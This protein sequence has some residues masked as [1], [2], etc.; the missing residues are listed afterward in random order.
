MKQPFADFRIL[1]FQTSKTWFYDI[2]LLYDPF[3]HLALT[4][5]YLMLSTSIDESDQ[6]FY[7]KRFRGDIKGQGIINPNLNAK[8]KI[9]IIYFHKILDILIKLTNKL[10]IDKIL[11]FKNM[12]TNFDSNTNVDNIVCSRVTYQK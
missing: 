8:T 7:I 5:G 9:E 11:E 10:V 3:K 6:K 12:Q 1:Y 2:K 4:R